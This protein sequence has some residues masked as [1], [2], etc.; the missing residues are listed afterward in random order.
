MFGNRR[1]EAPWSVPLEMI[2]EKVDSNPRRT[3]RSLV[4]AGLVVAMFL[5]AIEGTIVATAMPSIAARLGGFSMYGWVFSSYLLMQAVTTPVWGKLS[6][7]FGRKPVF[8]LGVMIFLVGCTLCGLAPSMGWLV[9][10][11]FIQGIGAGA[12]VTTT[13]TL[14][15]DLYSLRERGRVQGYLASVW[16]ISSILGPLAGGIIVANIDWHWIFWLNLP[17]GL[18]SLVLISLFLHERVEQRARSV[19]YAGAGLLL[20]GLMT[21]MLALTQVQSWGASRALLLGGAGVAVLLVFQRQQRTA[22]DPMMHPELW[23]NPIIRRGNLAVLCAGIAMI[24]LITFLPTFVQAVLGRSALVAG[25]TLTGMSLGWPIASVF[26]GRTFVK[27]GV[28][29]LVR[30]GGVVVILGALFVALFAMRGPLLAGVGAVLMG[31]GLGLLS[32]TYIV[33][34]QTSVTWAQRGV[35][36]AT[37]MLMRNLGSAMGAAML[38]S[39]LNVSLSRYIESR[40]LSGEISLDSVRELIQ[41]GEGGF[42]AG[43]GAELAASAEALGVLRD[44]LSSSLLLVFWTIVAFSAAI[45]VISAR[46]PDLD[47]DHLAVDARRRA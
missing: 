10:F 40:G 2:T 27:F 28:R 31:M 12:V 18:I 25:F 37:N 30:T 43:S 38:G 36:T 29:R 39:V 4:L 21:I 26:A 13:A 15:G 42:S 14:A 22:P 17:F 3:R 35:A 24:G 34:I 20:V 16:G 19:D 7:L 8:M 44:G 9:A 32:T 1:T 45:L 11:R 6:D 46:V 23:S 47:P 33:A 41:S 5:A